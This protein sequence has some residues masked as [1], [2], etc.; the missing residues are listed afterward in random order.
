MADIEDERRTPSGDVAAAVRVVVDHYERRGR[1]ALLMLAQ[2]GHDDVARKVTDRGK[3]MHRTWVREAFAPADRATSARLDLLVVATDVY[4]WKLLRIDRGLSRAVTERR[5]HDL[6]EAVLASP[7]P[8]TRRTEMAE[9]LVRHLGRRRQRASGRRHRHRAAAPRPRRPLRR[10]RPAAR[11]PDRRRVRRRTGARARGRSRRSTT[12]SPL[13]YDHDLR[14]PR[15][16]PR[17]AGG[18]RRPSGRPRRRRLHALRRHGRRSA[19]PARAYVVLEH[20]YDALLPAVLAARADGPR[21]AADAAR[22][23]RLAG[24]RAR[25]RWSRAC[26]RSTRPVRSPGRACAYVGPV[27]DVLPARG[28]PTRPC[29]S[30]S[31][32]IS[33]PQDA[34]VACRRCWTRPPGLDARVVVTTGP[35]VDP[36]SLRPAGQPRAAPLR[37]ARRADAVACP[38]SSGTAATRRP[39]RRWP[40]TCRWS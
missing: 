5:M 37:P 13:T 30:A 26:P 8:P 24:G 16:R 40:T 31:A 2:E 10:A 36:A 17:R 14:R 23:G 18:A 29:W 1:T 3:A 34:G 15:P 25:P 19:T 7:P 12:N 32:R 6:V 11:L 35:V 33:V 21:H 38:W 22:P 27:V 28:R 9:I 20:L 39:C 4:T